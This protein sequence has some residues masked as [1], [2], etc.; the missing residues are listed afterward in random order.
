[1]K[2][3]SLTWWMILF[4]VLCSSGLSTLSQA[5]LTELR[6][7]YESGACT[8][9]HDHMVDALRGYRRQL[10]RDGHRNLQADFMLASCLCPSPGAVALS[11]LSGRY[12]GLSEEDT[13][14]ILGAA[15]EC[16]NGR[17]ARYFPPGT[18]I[19]YV[20]GKGSMREEL[21]EHIHSQMSAQ[22][23]LRFKERL[24]K[25]DAVSQ[26]VQGLLQRGFK[27]VFSTDNFLVAGDYGSD[28][29]R[30]IGA[31]M[32]QVLQRL[33]RQYGLEPP[34]T[35]ITVYLFKT[36]EQ[37]R[38][39][40]SE[41]HDLKIS[42]GTWAYTF[43]LDASISVWRSGGTGTVGHEVMHA[44]LERNL[45]YAP[46]WLNEGSAA[47]FEEFR[48]LNGNGIQGTFRDDHW[49]I[50][51]LE[52][53]KIP[54]LRRLLEMDWAQFD[55]PLNFQVNHATAKM[56]ALYLQ[57]Q[58]KLGAM[59]DAYKGRDLFELEDDTETVERVLGMGVSGVEERF[60]AWLQNKLGWSGVG[61][62]DLQVFDELRLDNNASFVHTRSGRDWYQWTAFIAGPVEAQAR[63]NRVKYLLHPTFTP[64]ERI[65]DS[66]H[67]GH[68][69]TTTG[70][71]VF[72][73][74]AVVTLDSGKTKEY[75]HY[76]E[77]R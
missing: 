74:R 61:L 51:F 77:F 48:L 38:Q 5:G 6:Q 33:G 16:R 72:N 46:A 17:L 49:R 43:A 53:D 3:L 29:L 54:E 34:S 18:G 4:T 26:A 67:Y 68:P 30:S 25:R 45:P 12:R 1:M 42:E 21:V 56:L 76:L 39:H 8:H 50:P 7:Q 40:A 70:W 69:I 75:S 24:F 14:Q 22:A 41:V 55:H 31:L 2:I 57:E 62:A 52:R 36:K 66:S 65:G 23:T 64:S 60:H 20:G 13:E 11:D 27:R 28:E 15:F 19:A 37:L 73:L 35:L 58:G 63:I 9:N 71:G 10:W 59:L 32:E 44:L 47:L